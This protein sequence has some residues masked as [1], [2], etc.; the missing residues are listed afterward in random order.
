[1]GHSIIAL[2]LAPPFDDAA[3][4]RFDLRP[5]ALDAPLIL[6][7]VDHYF[8]AYWTAVL[9]L[10]KRPPLDRPASAPSIFP[11]ERVLLHMA[12]A[13][14]A[15]PAPRFAVIMKEYFGGM[16]DQWAAVYEGAST[17]P[18]DGS[19]NAALR[20]FAIVRRGD[21]DEFDTVGLSR[22]RSSPSYLDRYVAL[23]DDFDV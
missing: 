9:G 11:D 2:L 23:C 4:A 13:M 20:A 7:H 1:M 8:T 14:K 10:G 18:T 16:G 3:A 6:F 15:S 17:L 19:I 22:H 21:L 5:I 12:R